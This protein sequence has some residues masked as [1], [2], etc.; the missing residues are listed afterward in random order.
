MFLIFFSTFIKHAF[1]TN[2]KLC[3]Q[4]N[5]GNKKERNY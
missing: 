2:L 5:T 3:S 1:Y 4:K